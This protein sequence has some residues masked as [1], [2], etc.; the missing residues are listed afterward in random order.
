[1]SMD[2]IESAP[3]DSGMYTPTCYG[4]SCRYRS[5]VAKFAATLKGSPP[6]TGGSLSSGLSYKTNQIG[7]ALEC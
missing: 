4:S 6:V 7:Q 1:M 3:H 2:P 5:R